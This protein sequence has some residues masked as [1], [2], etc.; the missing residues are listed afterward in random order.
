M[1][2]TKMS[3]LAALCA[4]LALLAAGCKEDGKKKHQLPATPIV[5]KASA[6]PTAKPG[7][8]AP[9][10]ASASKIDTAA[11]DK[12]LRGLAPVAGAALLNGTTVAARTTQLTP[13]T[14][15]AVKKVLFKEG[16]VVDKGQLLVQLDRTDFLLGLRQA[17]AGRDVAIAGLNAV[18]VEWKRLRGLVK[19]KAIPSGQFDKVN[20]SLKV[21]QAQLAQ[22]KIGIAAARRALSK[23]AIR[24]PFRAV[25]TKKMTE[26]GA[27]AA[28]MPP[29]PV[30][31]LEQ[32]DPIE[33]VIQVPE[34]QISQVEKG[35]PVQLTFSAV[36]KVLRARVDRI[37][38]SLDQRTRAFSAYVRLANPGHKLRPGMFVEARLLAGAGQADAAKT[39]K[40][41]KAAKTGRKK[42]KGSK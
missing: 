40:T 19:A 20:S 12:A 8:V 29:T 37:V 42:A 5:P 1:S 31:M 14:S 30:V 33:I 41:A 22:A 36:G 11:T 18:K 9:G 15:A 24:A 7:E 17:Q 2:T 27:Y 3:R 39:A 16:D 23:T 13:Q 26:V 38:P 35:T 4:S 32:I 34:A 25:V 21:A 6:K 28:M 10:K